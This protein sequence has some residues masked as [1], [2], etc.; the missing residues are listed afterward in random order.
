MRRVNGREAIADFL[1]RSHATQKNGFALRHNI[2]SISVTKIDDSHAEAR[3][4]FLSLE[5][6]VA[7]DRQRPRSMRLQR[8]LHGQAGEIA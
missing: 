5:Q 6:L 3:S 2:S 7:P 4:Y 8:G 1:R